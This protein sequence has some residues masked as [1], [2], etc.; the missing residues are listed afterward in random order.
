MDVTENLHLIYKRIFEQIGSILRVQMAVCVL[1]Y[2]V[3]LDH[4]ALYLYF[5]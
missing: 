5:L 4:F 2:T 1:K 3:Y